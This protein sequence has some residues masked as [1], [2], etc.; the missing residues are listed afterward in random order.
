MS[1]KTTPTFP[2]AIPFT[3]EAFRKSVTD[4]QERWRAAM[5]ETTKVEQQGVA[6]AKMMVDEGAK[7]AH[8]T[9]NY[10]TNLGNEW[11]RIGEEATKRSLDLLGPR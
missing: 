6:H 7:I 11:R 3:G 1:E 4:A 2:F 9:L 5:L 10:W 8:E